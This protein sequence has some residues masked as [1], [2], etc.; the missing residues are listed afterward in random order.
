[1]TLAWLLHSPSVQVSLYYMRVILYACCCQFYLL[2]TILCFPGQLV[3][4]LGAPLGRI[5]AKVCGHLASRKSSKEH[6][7]HLRSALEC[8][9][10]SNSPPDNVQYA[11]ET[12]HR[13]QAECPFL[14]L[15]ATQL[16][17]DAMRNVASSD[18]RLGGLLAWWV[19]MCV[20]CPAVPAAL[21]EHCCLLE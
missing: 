21:H 10:N 14:L 20:A 11:K 9:A 5:L 15:Q 12:L 2:L 6:G 1:M 3:F 8:L 19:D 17:L 4:E 18:P 16:V 13:V 7:P